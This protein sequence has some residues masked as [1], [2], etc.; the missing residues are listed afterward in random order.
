[1]VSL[2][3]FLQMA[4]ESYSQELHLLRTSKG[5]LSSVVKMLMQLMESIG[6]HAA[7]MNT[8]HGEHFDK[9]GEILYKLC[10]ITAYANQDLESLTNDLRRKEGKKPLDYSNSFSTLL[11]N[12][13]LKLMQE[14]APKYG[15]SVTDEG[16]L[17]R[18]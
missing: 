5:Q 8:R 18:S 11:I 7:P 3:P 17:V 1:M 9:W 6:E 4:A 15:V 2:P 12:D 10:V 16:K 14:Q 13:W